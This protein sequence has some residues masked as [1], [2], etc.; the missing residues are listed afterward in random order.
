MLEQFVSWQ[1]SAL[2]RTES[3]EQLRVL[4]NGER[5]PVGVFSEK[6][7]P[8]VHV[9]SDVEAVLAVLKKI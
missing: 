2:E 8:G 1:P 4:A 3:L 6:I 7:P 5:I 9:P